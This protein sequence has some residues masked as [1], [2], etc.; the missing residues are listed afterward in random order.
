MHIDLST[1]VLN[2]KEFRDLQ[3]AFLRAS[4]PDSEIPS[5]CAAHSSEIHFKAFRH[6]YELLRVIW[7]IWAVPMGVAIILAV[8]LYGR[9]FWRWDQ[10]WRGIF[11]AL[12]LAVLQA[13][14][15]LSALPAVG[16][17]HMDDVLCRQSR[18]SDKP[19]EPVSCQTKL[20][21]N[22][23][24]FRLLKHLERIDT[25]TPGAL[26]EAQRTELRKA[27]AARDL[28]LDQGML[29]AMN[30]L[31]LSLLWH[32]VIIGTAV[33]LALG[34]AAWRHVRAR[35]PKRPPENVKLPR[36]IINR[37]N[38]GFLALLGIVNVALCLL[39][40]KE[41]FINRFGTLGGLLTKDSTTMVELPAE[42]V[43][44]II[45]AGSAIVMLSQLP[46]I[47]KAFGGVQHIMQDLI[48]HQYRLNVG[49]SG[50]LNPADKSQ[51]VRRQRIDKRMD[52]VISRFVAEKGYDGVVFLAHSQGTV[53]VFDYLRSSELAL[54]QRPFVLT[55]GAP[56]SALYEYY[57]NE[58]GNVSRM[59]T[60]MK[61]QPLR[62][63]NF[64][65]TDDPIAGP[66][67]GPI[68]WSLPEP[69]RAKAPAFANV[70]MGPGGH[71]AYWQEKVVCDE[72][73]RMLDQASV[74]VH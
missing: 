35:Y 60:E 42:V 48:D 46:L 65:R 73:M 59:M 56:V 7:A 32:T 58:Y 72:V 71:L 26:T 14:V 44:V 6:Y 51:P 54:R 50:M 5:G 8:G 52:A 21:D 31:S 4:T 66:I 1:V 64:Y 70:A 63:T 49:F 45:L 55:A 11:A 16:V 33:I 15:W 19:S 40:I 2:W 47:S 29:S 18:Y 69:A 30:E 61:L 9:N 39:W 74:G 12:A 24:A 20:R 28:T 41:P 3:L 23:V 27:I 13:C 34:A 36:L 68:S 67:S 53:I 57:F 10:G 25:Q 37:V 38:L 17:L 62:W 43:Q 22:A